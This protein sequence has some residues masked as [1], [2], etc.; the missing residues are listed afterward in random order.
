MARNGKEVPRSGGRMRKMQWPEGRKSA[1]IFTFD[2]DGETTW[3][4]GNRDLPNG[5]AYIKSISVGGYG[6]KRSAPLILDMLDKYQ[7][8][9]TFFI[10]GLTAERYP[11]V[12]RMIDAAGH[13]I[14]HHGYAHERFADKSVAEQ[15][16]I[17]ERAQDVYTRVLGRP[18]RGFRTPSGDWS[19]ETPSLLYERGFAYSSSMR[20]DDV[21]YRTV[22]NGKETDFIELPTKWELDDYV[23]MA[24]CLYP[25]KPSGQD[26]IMGY[27]QVFDNFE[28]EFEGCYRFGLP[29]V[30][31]FHPQIIGSPGQI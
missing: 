9:S 19:V 25:P 2:L 16:D 31:M 29:I 17:I 12:V 8:K 28:R 30:F 6:P 27:H 15:V 14:G 24:Y 3:E 13:E 11:D 20:G 1:A 26:R 10:P 5:G 18:V 22:I 23:Q 4:N 7:V 21:P